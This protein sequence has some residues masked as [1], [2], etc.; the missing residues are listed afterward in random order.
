LALIPSDGLSGSSIASKNLV[1]ISESN[2]ST[3]IF[4]LRNAIESL[5]M[6][7]AAAVDVRLAASA[8]GR[9]SGGNAASGE[10]SLIVQ[11]QG[12]G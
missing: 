9:I 4:P 5:T 8:T 6:L 11:S 2:A 7:L 3:E 10:M 12:W 1:S